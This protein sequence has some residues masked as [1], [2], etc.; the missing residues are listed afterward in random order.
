MCNLRSQ[1]DKRLVELEGIRSVVTFHRIGVKE[2]SVKESGVIMNGKFKS[3]A[4][5]PNDWRAC[6]N[7]S[8]GV[9]GGYRTHRDQAVGGASYD[10]SGSPFLYQIAVSVR[11]V[12]RLN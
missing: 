3:H 2:Q 11:A 8:L 4:A 5:C 1:K 12:S 6:S 9:I 7:P 10:S